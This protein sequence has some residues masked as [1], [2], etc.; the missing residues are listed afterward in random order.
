VVRASGFAQRTFDSL[1]D[2][3]FIRREYMPRTVGGPFPV[4]RPLVNR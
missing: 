4:Y 1:A 3:G 2:D